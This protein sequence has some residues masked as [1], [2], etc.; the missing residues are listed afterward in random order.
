MIRYARPVF[1]FSA[2]SGTGKTTLLTRLLPL[3]R[4]RG[5]RVAVI[6]HAHHSFD[7]DTPGKDSYRIREAGATQ[8]IVA[9]RQRMVLFRDFALPP[10]EPCLQTLLDTLDAA[11]TDLV[12]VEGFRHEAFAKIELCRPALGR[13]LLCAED[14]DIIA[15]ASDIPLELPRALPLLDLNRPAA[16]ADFL[17]RR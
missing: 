12:L 5:L 7:P 2:R 4:E 1:G 17:L 6:K 11:E 13:P 14:P 8:T 10:P 9:S 3:L 15:V 16:I